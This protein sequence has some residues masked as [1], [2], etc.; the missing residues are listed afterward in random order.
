[1]VDER[2]GLEARSAVSS[3]EDTAR[4]GAVRQSGVT[5]GALIDGVSMPRSKSMSGEQNNVK[6][7]IAPNWI[8][9]DATTE[10]GEIRR[11]IREF[12]R[13]EPSQERVEGI[14]R[15]LNAGADIE[16]SDDQWE[17][18][19]NTDS[20]HGIRPSHLE[21]AQRIAAQYNESL[22][23][24]NRR[25]FQKLLEGFRTGA[26]MEMP[27]IL[28]DREGVLHLVSGNTRLMISRALRIRSRVIIGEEQHPF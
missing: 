5:D 24:E 14:T 23:A 15:L 3:G 20:F 6:I 4:A 19:Q 28:K 16:L 7:E 18:L 2:P 8:R 10:D 26:S 12:L 22:P 21:D 1:M 27:M 9:P 17:A 11:V 25:D 13:E